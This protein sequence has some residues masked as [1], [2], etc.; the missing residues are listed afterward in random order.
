MITNKL[1]KLEKDIAQLLLEKLESSTITLERASE[2]AGFVI[3]SLPD[4]LTDEQLSKILLKLDD[5]FIE[6]ANI[7]NIHFMEY[8]EKKRQ[9]LISQ[10]QDLIHQN[11][12]EQANNL[13]KDYFYK[14]I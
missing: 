9:N 8:Q 5:Q 7:V 12:L 4:N 6:L 14:K 3:K 13:M 1:F 10:A 2:I 11:K